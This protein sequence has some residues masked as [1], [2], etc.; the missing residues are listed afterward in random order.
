MIAK[1]PDVA[2]HRYGW[3]RRK[4]EVVGPIGQVGLVERLYPK[5]DLRRFE[6]LK[7]ATTT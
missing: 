6:E 3:S 7:R 1:V 4:M 5:I 2:V